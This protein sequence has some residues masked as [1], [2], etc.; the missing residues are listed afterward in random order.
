MKI[1]VFP[2]KYHQNGEL[3]MAMLVYRRV[4]YFSLAQMEVMEVW[5]FQPTLLPQMPLRRLQLHL[6]DAEMRCGAVRVLVVEK[7][8]LVG[9]EG[10]RLE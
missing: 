6:A 4:R 9:L 8:R 7:P 3:S 5:I 2:G 10:W 1:P